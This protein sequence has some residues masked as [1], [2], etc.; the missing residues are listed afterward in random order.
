MHPGVLFLVL[1]PTLCKEKVRTQKV[2]SSMVS[3][4]VTWVMP[5]VSVPR[6]GQYW[7]HFIWIC[8]HEENMNMNENRIMNIKQA[9]STEVY[10]EF[11]A[12]EVTWLKNSTKSI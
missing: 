5:Y 6:L 10:P 1:N 4:R 3:S 8:K 2:A 12:P 9:Q 11:L 7:S